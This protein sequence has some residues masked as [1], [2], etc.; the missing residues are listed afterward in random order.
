M[1]R[2]PQALP[3]KPLPA[4][5]A[6]RIAQARA[7]LVWERFA[8]ILLW[9]VLAVL[10]FL[11]GAF[12][13]VWQRLGDPWRLIALAAALGIL[14]WSVWRARGLRLPTRSLAQRRLEVDNGLAHRPLDVI[15]DSP[16]VTERGWN[17]HLAKA[18]LAVRDLRGPRVSPVLREPDRL[19]SRVWVPLLFVAG[20]FIG[21]GDNLERL[22]EA[23]HPSWQ[24]GIDPS[25]AS[26]EAWI[27]PPEYTGRRPVTLKAGSEVSIP[28]GSEFIARISGVRDVP[29]LRL[30]EGG[31]VRR[32]SATR[33]GPESFEV[34]A[35][36][37]DDATAA[38]RIGQRRQAWD[39]D[40][41]ADAPPTV[42]FAETPKA[43]KRDR[44]G[45]TFDLQDDY[46]V[47]TLQLELQ[48]L[49]DE[50]EAEVPAEPVDVPLRSAPMKS[51]E[52][53]NQPLD[54][55]RHRW[56]GRKVRAVLLATDGLGQV[57]RSEPAY[58]TVPNRIF[59]E[60]LAK[61]VA[62]Q[63]VLVVEGLHATSAD[64]GPPGRRARGAIFDERQPELRLERAPEPLQRAVALIDAVTE[65][66]DGAFDDPAL[67]MGLRE[68]ASRIRYA[69]GKDVLEGLDNDLWAMAIRAEFGRLGTALEAM[70]R[71]QQQLNDAIA[72]RAPQ[73]EVDVLFER[74]NEAVD[75]YLE[76]LREE[77]EVSDEE[78]AGGGGGAG[79][80]NI[81]EI[82]ELL[83]AIEEA[84][85]LGDTEGARLALARLAELLENMKIE[86][87]RGGG[88]GDGQ[89]Q[90][91]GEMSEEMRE[92]LEELADLLGEQRDL[93]DDT[94]QAENGDRSG[95]GQSREDAQ[96]GQG[97]EQPQTGGGGQ[98]PGELQD[99]QEE[100]G[101]GLG[102]LRELLP[103]EEAAGLGEEGEEARIALD[104]AEEAMERAADELAN[105]DL[106]AAGEA[107]EEAIRQ[108]RAAGLGL[109]R[110]LQNR[111]GEDTDEA[112]AGDNPL[113]QDN[114][115]GANDPNADAD[116]D[117]RSNAERSREILEELRR[118]AAEQERS[119][120]ERDY[121]ERL[122]KRF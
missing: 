54:L 110:G 69:R 86:L 81:D 96:S 53:Q 101:Q 78:M 111:D 79:G 11:A 28:E 88:G 98:S 18:E 93:R 107:Q 65:L 112:N 62:E 99:R 17:E 20:A 120:E 94:E 44:L 14:G 105:G 108:L 102:A 43:D 36:L 15:E 35:L 47:E 22:R 74:Y 48:P 24:R 50:G 61:A 56:A 91:G 67:Y 13:G 89:P 122:M 32:L 46:G 5:I 84:Q 21:W 97:G 85:R 70:Q 58:F 3:P 51:A 72:R 25:A 71:A 118:R 55:T 64:Y 7:V 59:V 68:A 45:L 116:I 104:E 73:R 83:D 23:L 80:R 2:P 90:P 30:D 117:P 115:N 4:R 57:A 82:Q 103:E 10:L 87:Q 52:A 37:N 8:P 41:V 39:L 40:V 106:G 100:L 29:R 121:L 31:R 27:D 60:P 113:G 12:A 42:G 6:A 63:R 26:F 1:S 9:G 16:R 119:Q 114:Q 38:F 49:V 95:D 34:R 75:R 33:L 76:V 19:G 77:A 109:A 66:P 92:S